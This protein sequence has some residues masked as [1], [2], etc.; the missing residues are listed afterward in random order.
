MREKT[1]PEN[2]RKCTESIQGKN[3]GRQSR[4]IKCVKPG[5]GLFP[6]FFVAQVPELKIASYC[7]LPCRHTREW[8]CA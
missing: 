4:A 5:R 7:R 1:D 8:V 2:M 6:L 3:G